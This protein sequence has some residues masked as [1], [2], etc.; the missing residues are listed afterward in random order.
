[1][2]KK[3]KFIFKNKKNYKF[4]LYFLVFIV[5]IFSIY[6]LIPNFF[7]YTPKQIQESF[8]T[9]NINIKNISNINYKLLP[10]PR[11]RLS[12]INLDLG[13]GVLKINDAQ[14]DIM[15]KP[16][17]II[18]YKNLN[19]KKLL[20]R[21]GS[22]TIKIN[23][24]DQILNY[25]KENQTKINF[26]D[27]NIILLRKEKKIFQ[28]NNSIIKINNKNNIQQLDVKGLFLNHKISFNLKDKNNSKIYITLKVPELDISANILLEDSDNLT[29]F[30]ALIDLEVLN[31]FFQFN[32]TKEKNITIN[33]G[34]VRSVLTNS[35]FEGNV[36]FSPY[37]FFNLNIKPTSINIKKLIFIIQQKY[38]L[39]NF[40][41][42]EFLKTMDGYLNFKNKSGEKVIFKN[43]E[44]LVQN[45]K[46][47]KKKYIIFDAKISEFGKKGKIKFKLNDTIKNIHISGH[48]IPSSL[49]INF[50]RITFEKE[51]FTAKKVKNYEEKFENEVVRNSLENIFNEVKIN[52]FF[53]SF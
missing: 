50:E 2:N 24:V 14:V 53:K 29:A 43:R 8:K 16:L 11:L 15:L 46:L 26:K 28:I 34:F 18:D 12:G 19:Y 40:Y 6:F 48:L 23:Q 17:S 10:S 41:A 42:I 35:A 20:I 30:K 33:R 47:D 13:M 49:K 5:F 51:I 25:I 36:S 27:N 52:N 37:F 44:I 22:T 31:N 9:S 21:G 45:F 1:M 38:F 32:L 4:I 7:H 39:E 3:L